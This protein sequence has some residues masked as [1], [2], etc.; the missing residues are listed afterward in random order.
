MIFEAQDLGGDRVL[1]TVRMPG[2]SV[3]Q[4]EFACCLN[5]LTMGFNARNAGGLIQ[6]AFPFLSPGEREFLMTGITPEEWD[7]IFGDE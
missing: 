4:M 3:K 5:Q 6:D 1:M 2:G 7:S